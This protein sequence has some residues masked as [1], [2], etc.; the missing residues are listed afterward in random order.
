[1]QITRKLAIVKSIH[2]APVRFSFKRLLSNTPYLSPWTARDLINGTPTHRSYSP[3]SI[4]N[5]AAAEGTTQPELSSKQASSKV[6]ILIAGKK[7]EF[8]AVLLRDA[9]SCPLCVHESTK[10]R[11]FSTA[12]I[13]AG[14][15]SQAVEIDPASDSVN[16]GWKNDIPGFPEEHTTTLSMAA[17]RQLSCSGSLPGQQRDSF[18]PPALW[19]QEPPNLVDYDY[20]TYMQNDGTLHQI[21]NQLE[22]EGLAFVTNV[23]GK[24][25]SLASIATRIG[26]VKDTFYGYTWDGRAMSNDLGFHTDLLYF[27]QPLHIQLL[28]CVQSASSGGASVFADAFKAAVDFFHMDVDA[29]N[30]LATVPVNYHYNHPHSNMYR[31]TKP[32]I[33][34]RP[35]G[36]GHTIYTG[37]QDYIKDW[38][39]LSMRNGGSGWTVAML[40][41][42]MDKINWRPPFLAP[43]SIHE[44]PRQQEQLADPALSALK[45]KVDRWHQAASKFSGPLQHP[46]CLYERKMR[47]GECVLFSNTRILHSRR[48]FD[49]AEIGKPRWLRGTYADKDPY[50]SKLRVL[51]HKFKYLRAD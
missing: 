17:L 50:F 10:Q 23:P 5:A 27:E 29:F 41:D 8:L 30:T 40:V 33:D 22:A 37:I 19:G 7:A 31:T 42:C 13:P 15:Q 36:I 21:I 45:N 12:D 44:V 9:C 46:E 28:H 43:F 2:V 39:E 24:E 20:N 48:A 4:N 14:I 49:M 51:Q 18:R 3:R 11:L 35:L 47:P 26:P 38:H 32:V 16:I 25:E 6:P 1:M 34:L